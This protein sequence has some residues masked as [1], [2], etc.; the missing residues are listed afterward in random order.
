MGNFKRTILTTVSLLGVLLVAVGCNTKNTKVMA[1]NDTGKDTLSITILQTADIH[2]QLDT[3]PE[4]FWEEEKVVFKDRGGLANIKTLFELERQKNPGRTIIVDGG[5]LIQGSG[6]TALSEGKVMPDI[7][8]GMGYDVII[9]GNWEV[10]YGK[11]IMMD[12][13]KGYETD[14]IVQNM[15]HE[16]SEEPLFPAYSIKEIGGVRIGFIG[17]ND[18]DVP[19]RQNPIF[20]T[21]IGFSGLDGKLK[22]M[23]DDIKVNEN[24]DVLFLVTHIGIFKQVELANNPIAENVDYV[25]GNDTHERV[26]KPI[27]GKYAKVTEPGAFGSFVGKLTLHFV[28]GKLVGDDYELIDVDPNEFPADKEVQTLVDK[29]KA[30]YREHLETVVGYT[31]TPIYRYLTVENPMDNMITDAARWKTG[32]D[33]SISN[34]FRFGNPIVPEN[35]KPAP[36]TRANLWNLLPVNEKV[37]TGKATG[38]QIKAWLEE[39]MHNAFS[40]NPTERFGGWLVR[41]SGMKV[42]FNSQNEKGNRISTITVKGRPMQD[43]EYYT[44]SACVRPGDP[45]DNL[46]RMPNVKDVEVKDYTI[47]EVVEE[48]LKKNSPVSPTLEGRAYC[49]YLGTYSF[50]TIPETDYIFQ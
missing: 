19:V 4:L 25:L 27:Q 44:I 29:A 8:K 32:A 30:P 42:N 31:E 36:I 41:F 18:P 50:S 9:P 1:S 16:K 2:G 6:Y 47:H 46:C 17:I 37:K 13:M 12:V 43:D 45:L 14:V 3:H 15:Y 40:Q 38:K 39:E 33:I 48:Y 35:G 26:R 21:G 5:D 34:G 11:D 10:V 22:K 24:V 49:E 7:I 23:V 20:S 28:D